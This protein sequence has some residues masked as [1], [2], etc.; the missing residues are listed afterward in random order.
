M[1]VMIEN[2]A[3]ALALLHWGVY[4]THLRRGRNNKNPPI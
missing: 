2:D 3:F 1:T 4:L